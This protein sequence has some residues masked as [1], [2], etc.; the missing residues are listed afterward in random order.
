MKRLQLVFSHLYTFQ[1][2]SIKEESVSIDCIY[3]LNILYVPKQICQNYIRS[4]SV[5]YSNDF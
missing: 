5:V 2:I 3:N 4:D 1:G